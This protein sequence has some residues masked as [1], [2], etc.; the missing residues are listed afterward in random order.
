MDTQ[1]S[2]GDALARSLATLLDLGRRAREARSEAELSFLLVNDSL[3]L[4]PYRQAALWWHGR[5][6]ATLS[7][8][9]QADRNAPYV[10]WLD[11]LARTVTTTQPVEDAAAPRALVANDLPQAVAAE[12]PQW[13][14]AHGLW[15]P[16]AGGPS[17][18]I[19]A[20]GPE[21]GLL[22]AGDLPFDETAQALWREWAAA[23]WHAHTAL[24]ATQRRHGLRLWPWT[25]GRAGPQTSERR[26]RWWRRPGFLLALALA[27]AAFVPVRLSVLAPG[28]L[29]PHQPTV[30]RAPL[31][32]V[33]DV[34]HVRPNQIVRKGQPLFGFDEALIQ[35]RLEVAQQA[36]ATATTEKR[37]AQQQ[38]LVDARVRPQLAVLDGRIEERRAEVAY[39]RDQLRRTRVLS[40]GEGVALLDDATEWIGRPVSVG[41]RVLRIAAVDDIEV[42]AW[43]PIADAIA[44]APGATVRL[45]LHADPLRP[46]D[47]RLRLLAHE[48]V[49]RPD[50]GFAY[51]IRATLESPTTHRVGLKGTAKIEGERV[52]ALYWAL[53][54]PIAT[55]RA[56]LGL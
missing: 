36:L 53:R 4:T 14:P 56:T 21:A 18:G 42:E 33:I 6:V 45:Y 8:L 38:A 2:A 35:S 10:Q 47:A 22:L 54:R 39:L 46:V 51:R 55:V 24:R 43:L 28:E 27:A 17:D 1:T 32:G 19:A 20:E 40:P 49:Q 52:I 7:G 31:D 23:W 50:G 48:A 9:V 13:W 15:V 37:Q 3:A 29:V 34:F 41:E 25:G 30:V 11:R 26:S 5:G 12:W 16:L 44:L